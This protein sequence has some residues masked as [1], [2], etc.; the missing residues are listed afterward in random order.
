MK[1][2]PG[3]DRSAPENR[4]PDSDRAGKKASHDDGEQEAYVGGKKKCGPTSESEHRGQA[5]WVWMKDASHRRYSELMT[6]KER[7]HRL[8]D[9]LSDQE[10]EVALMLIEQRRAA[11]DEPPES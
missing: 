3:Q 4:C 6:A 2:E 10:A 9:A 1:N 7:L 5:I 8:I 11:G